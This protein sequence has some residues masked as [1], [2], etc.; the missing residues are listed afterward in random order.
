MLVECKVCERLPLCVGPHLTATKFRGSAKRSRVHQQCS[1]PSR[2]VQR[3]QMMTARCAAALRRSAAAQQCI[4][5]K[6]I[7]L[8]RLGCRTQ[9]HPSNPRVDVAITGPPSAIDEILAEQRKACAAP[10]APS[11]HTHSP[12]SVRSVTSPPSLGTASPAL[13]A[14]TPDTRRKDSRGQREIAACCVR[15]GWPLPSRWMWTRAR[16]LRLPERRRK[17]RRSRPRTAEAQ[18]AGAGASGD[19]PGRCVPGGGARSPEAPLGSPS[20]V[21]DAKKMSLTRS[22]HCHRWPIAG[23][24]ARRHAPRAPR[25]G[26]RG[27]DVGRAPISRPHRLVRRAP[28]SQVARRRSGCGLT[29]SFITP[30]LAVAFRMLT[31]G[32]PSIAVRCDDDEAQ[33][34]LRE[35]FPEEREEPG[36]AAAAGAEGAESGEVAEGGDGAPAAAAAGEG[37]AAQLGTPLKCGPLACSRP[38][39]ENRVEFLLTVAERTCRLFGRSPSLQV[40]AG[41]RWPRA[42]G[43]GVDVRAGG[44]GS[45][46]CDPGEA[47]GEVGG[48]GGDAAGGGAQ[49]VANASLRRRS[50]SAEGR[51]GQAGEVTNR[52]RRLS[53]QG[54]TLLGCWL[55]AKGLKAGAGG[56]N[57]RTESRNG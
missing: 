37:A 8:S 43:G 13:E 14:A 30:P 28:V 41:A 26:G 57:P 16:R 56:A 46:R 53:G 33:K 25:A 38:P 42:A 2:C 6:C 50:G 35:A 12:D 52:Q 39:A 21:R 5:V 4:V 18:T 34:V 3:A 15:S 1:A 40:G 27:P 7:F 45:D 9:G 31:A 47:R 48:G 20:F 51:S 23:V 17:G 49:A 10:P 24:S 11:P 36:S 22:R 44:A 29:G 19:R 55:K 32:E 54:Q